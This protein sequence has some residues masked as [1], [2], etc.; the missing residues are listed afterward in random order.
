MAYLLGIGNYPVRVS[1]VAAPWQ[2]TPREMR[3]YCELLDGLRHVPG[4]REVP[5]V[6]AL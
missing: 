5:R 2:Q 4:Q 1:P 3:N 6:V